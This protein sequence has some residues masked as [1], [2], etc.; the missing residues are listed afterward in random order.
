MSRNW[1]SKLIPQSRL[2][3]FPYPGPHEGVSDEHFIVD[4]VS[5]V[6]NQETA[7]EDQHVQGS[8][9]IQDRWIWASVL[10][11]TTDKCDTCEICE[12][13]DERGFFECDVV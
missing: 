12:N 2:D 8:Q 10:G 1:G 13:F 4:S 5:G 7:R 6:Y 9:N 3:Y 11:D